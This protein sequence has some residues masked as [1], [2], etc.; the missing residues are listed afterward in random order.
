[1]IRKPG[2]F[3]RK[4]NY[5][6][7]LIALL[8]TILALN[9]L[10]G[11]AL[12]LALP[13]IKSTLHLTDTELGVLTGIAFSLFYSTVGIPLG[14][15]ADRGDRV[16][17][18]ALTTALW[19]V[20]VMLVGAARSFAQLLAVRVGVAI[21]E[22]GCVPAAYSLIGDYFSREERPRAIANFLLGACVSSIV[23]YLAAGWLSFHYGWRAMFVCLG[24]P[25]VAVAPL[26]WWTLSE[27]RRG[28][29]G[30]VHGSVGSAR[31]PRMREVIQVLWKTR[32]FRYLLATCCVNAIFGSGFAVWQASF[33]VRSYGLRTEQLGMYFALIYGVGGII[34]TYSGGYLASR[35]APNNERLQ[36]RVLAFLNAGFAVVS[37]L[38]Y[39]ST[40]SS[41]SMALLGLSVVGVAFENGPV[42]AALQAVI[43]ERTRAI[44]VS[45]IYL[46]ANLLGVGMGPLLV[47]ALSD[48]LRSVLGAESLR[49]ALL[50]MCPGFI[51]GGWLLWEAARGISADAERI[52]ADGEEGGRITCCPSNERTPEYEATGFMP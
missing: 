26:A 6:V 22:A 43:P 42:Y 46:L 4:P 5:P 35:H 52:A 40:K 15:W 21:G 49:Y 44:S 12:G 18:L 3:D 1:M 10:D 39:L 13:G 2:G 47:G 16:A 11:T 31:T 14:R 23:G 41:V 17:I 34:G 38:I 37:A 45:V 50:A 48:T 33:F 7:Y 24:A 36:L 25:S 30:S 19:G 28:G 29:Q 8:A 27:P 32:T 51:A 9:N 20:M